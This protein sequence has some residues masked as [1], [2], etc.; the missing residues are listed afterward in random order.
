MKHLTPKLAR[1]FLLVFAVLLALLAASYFWRIESK[2]KLNT[3]TEN[4]VLLDEIVANPSAFKGRLVT[5]I[6]YLWP[7]IEGV[8]LSTM[9]PKTRWR[10]NK[11]LNWAECLGSSFLLK[12]N[13]ACNYAK[14]LDKYMD[15]ESFGDNLVLVQGYVFD[16]GY[17]ESGQV[18]AE[19]PYMHLVNCRKIAEV[20]LKP[21]DLDAK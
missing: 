8:G 1:R 10:F 19:A 15:L 3:I 4:P 13:K 18:L 5:T 7:G 9:P 6:C 11:E 14:S 21:S 20:I 2:L 12:D 17:E 16:S